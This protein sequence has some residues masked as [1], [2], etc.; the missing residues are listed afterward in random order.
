MTLYQFND[1][2]E[3]EQFEELWENGVHIGERQEDKYR[4]VLYQLHSFYVELFYHIEHNVLHRLR[5]FSST[6][7]LDAY[8]KMFNLNEL[9]S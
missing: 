1:L 2:D 5:S 8:L 6:E 7:Q 9:N 4:I 3:L